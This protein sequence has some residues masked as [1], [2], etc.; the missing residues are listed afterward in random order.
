MVFADGTSN[1]RKSLSVQGKAFKKNFFAD[2]EV[3]QLHAQR[4]KANTATITTSCSF[5]RVFLSLSGQCP[6]NTV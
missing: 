2:V 3:S 4:L 5:V 1:E 6:S